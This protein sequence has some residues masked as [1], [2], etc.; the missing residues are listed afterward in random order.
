MS[1][2]VTN[3]AVR[4]ACWAILILN[5][6][7][8][9]TFGQTSLDASPSVRYEDGA[10]TVH[11]RVVRQITSTPLNGASLELIALK[12]YIA[13][14]GNSSSAQ[15]GPGAYAA[16]SVADG[17]FC[18]RAVA[19]GAYFLTARMPG[20]LALHY[21]AKNYLQSGSIVVPPQGAVGQDLQLALRLP[22]SIEGTVTDGEGD[23]VPDLNV[24]AIRQAWLN[25]HRILVPMS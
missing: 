8:L 12:K 25:G 14:P 19:P 3:L 24:I 21:G 4:S 5:S 10:C 15:G 7:S 22:G 13:G 16:E 11:G 17:S 18:F 1:L 9:P 23:P 2:S 20:F 6:G